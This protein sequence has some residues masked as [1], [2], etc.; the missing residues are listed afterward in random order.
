MVSSPSEEVSYTTGSELKFFD[1]LIGSVFLPGIAML[2]WI[3]FL[4]L[5]ANLFVFLSPFRLSTFLAGLGSFV[6]SVGVHELGHLA[7]ARYL[8][9]TIEEW[10]LV[11]FGIGFRISERIESRTSFRI[12]AAGPLA[13][14]A[15]GLACVFFWQKSLAFFL[16]I[17]SNFLFLINALPHRHS[18]GFKVALNLTNSSS[19]FAYLYVASCFIFIPISIVLILS[20][21]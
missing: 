17:S 7:V 19:S 14:L 21:F 2:A 4:F 1:F 20:I 11:P 18:D 12:I 6:T 10:R 16:L 3:P 13:N 9:V 8:K 15:V 5:L